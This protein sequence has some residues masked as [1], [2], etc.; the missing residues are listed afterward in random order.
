MP[1]AAKTAK[2]A[3]VGSPRTEIGVF[4]VARGGD[5]SSTALRLDAALRIAPLP[6]F[7]GDLIL[8]PLAVLAASGFG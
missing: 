3:K 5:A 7:L 8:A 2:T 1:D 6:Q 4:V